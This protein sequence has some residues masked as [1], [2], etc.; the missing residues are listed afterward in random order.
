MANRTVQSVQT[1]LIMGFLGVGKTT[2]LRSLLAHKPQDERWAILVNE[3]GEIGVDAT[4]L[5]DASGGQTIAVKQ[6]PGGC[7]CCAAGPVTRVSLNALLRQERPDRLLI[8][9]SGLGHPADILHLLKGSGY[10]GVLDVRDAI[11][12]VDPR[13]AVS[14][15]YQA[16]DLFQDQLRIADR[17]VF[18]K[19]DLC[20]DATR[21]EAEDWIRQRI[22]PDTP[23]HAVEQGE[24]DYAWLSPPSGISTESEQWADDATPPLDWRSAPETPKPGHWL[25]SSHEADGY[26]SLGWRISPEEIWDADELLMC[27]H[28]L[29]LVRLKGAVRTQRGWLGFNVAQGSLSASEIGT[30]VE[31]VIEC[32]HD[33]PVDAD[34][35]AQQ[36]QSC[37]IKIS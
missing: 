27:L 8:E 34:S 12:L 32:I 28:E 18:N 23:I 13:Q 19:T 7:M 4:F 26:Y 24:L 30:Q 10:R 17:V 5:N 3:F 29:D 16:L 37:Q 36:L 21:E 25:A 22:R 2:A 20:D 14:P 9:P 35:L 6:I 33:A 31:S 15:R 1:H 11:V